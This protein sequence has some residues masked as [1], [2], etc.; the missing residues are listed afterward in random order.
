MQQFLN[1]VQLF[2][3]DLYGRIGIDARILPVTFRILGKSLFQTV[4]NADIVNDQ[5]A[6]F[7]LENP[8]HAGD[9]LH[10]V[11]SFHGLVDV[12]RMHAGHIKAGQ[13]HIAHNHELQL[14]LCIF[15]ACS[16]SFARLFRPDKGL[17][18]RRICR[19]ASHD[20]LDL[21]LHEV[22]A[23]PIRAQCHNFMI[24]IYSN[25]AAH[26][27]DHCL[28]AAELLG[29][30]TFLKML[31]DI[32]RHQL[33]TFAC[34]DNR[35]NPR[36]FAFELFP[37][38]LLLILRDFLI[39][40]VNLRLEFIR[41]LQLCDPALVVDA[42]S[43]AILYR[44][45]HIVDINVVAKDRA[46]I[47][48][49]FFNRRPG[50]PDI[51]RIRQTVVHIF[52]IAILDFG[53]LAVLLHHIGVKAILA[54][55]RFI[56]HDNDIRT[57]REHRHRIACFLRGEFLNGRKDDA[58]AR[59]LIQFGAQIAAIRC[60][61]RLGTQKFLGF[62]EGAEKLIIQIVAVGNDHDGRIRQRV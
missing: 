13:P 33:D 31:D 42:H 10:E 6:L 41:Q 29:L 22:I 60:L 8:I 40:A 61:I 39:V 20:D 7:I 50:K 35:L 48:V 27:H 21:P 58:A 5:A 47:A 51:G 24:K 54:A 17:P 15:H 28:A 49:S 45:R 25:P 9:G 30:L 26:D 4:G 59:A 16:Q 62:L 36:P 23:V 56:R 12:H 34:T 44:P 57:F 52:C 14:V 38:A 2:E 3:Q 37:L 53:G 32:P 18:I 19:A 46:C 43:R 11:M 55:V 1:E